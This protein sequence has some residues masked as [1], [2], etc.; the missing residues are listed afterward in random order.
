MV[1][2]VGFCL[3]S[4][5]VEPEVEVVGLAILTKGRNDLIISLPFPA[6][7]SE[8][9]FRLKEGSTYNLKFSFTVRHNV[10]S[11]L[12]YLNTVWRAGLQGMSLEICNV[13][14][15]M[16]TLKSCEIQL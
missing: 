2:G 3:D 15:Y 5:K 16:R 1:S 10:V 9:S 14:C 12:T 7:K 6:N 13:F 8:V 11:G 4:E